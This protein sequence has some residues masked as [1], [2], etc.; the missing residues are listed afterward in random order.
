[1]RVASSEHSGKLVSYFASHSTVQTDALD[2]KGA[3]ASEHAQLRPLVVELLDGR[4]EEVYWGQVPEK[5][6]KQAVAKALSAAGL[7]AR[8]DMGGEEIAIGRKRRRRK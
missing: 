6:R 8:P 1:M 2:D 3:V 5:V 4:Q 7:G